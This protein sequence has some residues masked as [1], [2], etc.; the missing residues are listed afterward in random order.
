[1]LERTDPLYNPNPF[2]KSNLCTRILYLNSCVVGVLL[3]TKGSSL[4]SYMYVLT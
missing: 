2:V 1:M 3:I 4:A